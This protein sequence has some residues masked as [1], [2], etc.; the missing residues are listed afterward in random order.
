MLAIKYKV[1]IIYSPKY[2]RELNAIEG[3]W[4]HQKAFVCARSDQSFDKM[5]RLILG[6]HINFAERKTSLKLFR[7]F[8]RAIKAYSEGQTYADVLQLF[9]SQFCRTTIQSHRKITNTSID[10]G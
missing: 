7:R 10:E 5:V 6:S 4:C 8:W 3:L 2:H 9:F 1:K